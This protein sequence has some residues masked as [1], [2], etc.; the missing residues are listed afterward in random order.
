[1]KLKDLLAPFYVW[2]RTFEKPYTVRKPLEEREGEPGYRGFHTN[3][4]DKCIGCGTCSKICQNESIDMVPVDE[5]KTTVRDSGLRPKIDYGR[6][7]WCALCVDICPTGS[8]GMASEFQWVSSDP[9]EFR[10]VPGIDKKPWDENKKGYKRDKDLALLCYDRIPMPSLDPEEGINS[11][12]ELI[13]GYSAEQANKEADRCIEC[14]ICIATCP[15]HMDIPGYIRA[16]REN[17]IDEGLRIIYDTNPLPL[18]CGRVCTHRCE[19]VCA[20]S[21]NG[22]PLAIRW[23]KRYI[24]DQI[25][26]EQYDKIT[27]SKE[28]SNGKKVAVIG[29]GPGGMAAAW[30]LTLMG[31][32]VTIFEKREQ[33]GGMLRYGIP[34]YRLPYSQLDRDINVILSLG[35]E[36]KT[37]TR[38]GKD[39]SFDNLY[40]DHDAIF[41]STG[42]SKPYDIGVDGEEH[43]RVKSGLKILDDVT[44]G[45]DPEVGKSVAVIGGGNVA[46][47]AARTSRRYGAEVTIYYRRRVEDMPADEE[48]I[49]ESQEDGVVF[50]TQAIPLE[51]TDAPNGQVTLVWGEAEMVDQGEGKRPKP[52]LIEGSRKEVVVDTIIA[53]IGQDADYSFLPE[54]FLTK[55]GLDKGKLQVSEAGQTSDPKIFAGGDIANRVRDAISAIAD[56]HRAARGIDVFLNG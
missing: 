48:E 54:S 20:L 50:I 27:K 31:Y 22:E 44:K 10:Y 26:P 8:L 41:F 15:G 19:Y 16:I 3:D 14:G 53:A 25:Q 29:S 47:D 1:M 37:H 56:G 46:M 39:I 55:L 6:C 4:H 34:E 12:V 28:L 11:F 43:D 23:L 33:A 42:L 5:I 36:L 13:Q 9:D 7:C 38:V 30:Y 2:K 17:N 32:A 24:A 45:I 21:K 51:I 52:V 49:H 18:V 35:V 40:A